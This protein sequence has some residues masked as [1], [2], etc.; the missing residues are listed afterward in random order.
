MPGL[1]RVVV[2]AVASGITAVFMRASRGHGD[3]ARDA[4]QQLQARYDQ[5][6]SDYDLL[7]EENTQLKFEAQAAEAVRPKLP[8]LC[9]PPA[10]PTGPAPKWFPPKPPKPPAPAPTT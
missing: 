3:D 9:P 8:K 7:Q 2:A 1:G 6:R 5:L 4:Q 10:R